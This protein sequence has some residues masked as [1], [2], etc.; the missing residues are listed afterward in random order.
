MIMLLRRV[1]GCGHA[2]SPVDLKLKI[3]GLKI[4]SAS[5]AS[6]GPHTYHYENIIHLLF[7]TMPT[8]LT[9]TRKQ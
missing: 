8:R 6:L 2:M 5:E 9:K 1:K 3:V 4:E 7:A